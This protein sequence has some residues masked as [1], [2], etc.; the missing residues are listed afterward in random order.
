MVSAALKGDQLVSKLALQIL[1]LREV[2]QKTGMGRTWIYDHMAD[3][4]FPKSFPLGVRCVGWYE[5]EVDA[6]LEGMAATRILGHSR[7]T[8]R[9]TASSLVHSG[10]PDPTL[11]CVADRLCR[12]PESADTSEANHTPPC[13]T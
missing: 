2:M 3:G 9:P 6:W 12:R 11:L 8:I 10:A 7:A 5:H 1:R 4:T 13:L